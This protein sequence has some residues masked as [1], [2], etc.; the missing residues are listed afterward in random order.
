MTDTAEGERTVRSILRRKVRR[1]LRRRRSQII[2]VA[3]TVFLGVVLFTANLDASHNLGASYQSF[4]DQ[5]DTADVWATGGPTDRMAADFAGTPGVTAVDT[6]S[7]VDLPARLDGRE[8]VATMIGGPEDGVFDVNRLWIDKGRDLRPGDTDVV[9]LEKHA[10]DHFHLGP[11]D[12]VA[13]WNGSAWR[14]V[15]IVGV[16]A[17]GEY[18]F[19]ARSHTEVFT[20]P[21]EFAVV[22]VP[23][24]LAREIAPDAPR[25]VAV[26]VADRDP[27]LSA[28]LISRARASG[29]TEIYDLADQPSN[30]ALQSDV[31]GFES[32]SYLF[33]VLFL[34]AAG[35]ATFVLLSRLV[36][37]ER[38]QIGMMVADGIDTSTILRHYM[39]HALI[40]TMSGAI[41]GLIAGALLGRWISTLYTGFIG[42]PV[43]VM[44]YSVATMIEAV[45]FAVIVGAISG[46]LPARAAA[47]IDPAESMRPPTPTGVDSR[48]LLERV[49]PVTMPMT[50]KVVL[51]NMARNPRRVATTAVGVVLSMVLLVTSL[52][53]N[54][55]TGSVID[56]QFSAID[57]RDLSVHLDHPVTEADLAGLATIPQVA[58]AE[59]SLELPVVVSVDGRRSEQLLQVFRSNTDAHGFDR[60][61]PTTG[62][63]LGSV[64]RSNLG[65]RV[66]DVVTV[67]VPSMGASIE[68]PVTGFVDEPI[69]S[70]SY[71]SLAA[72][73]AA[74]GSAPTTAVVTLVD[75][76]THAAV[77]DLLARRADVLAVTDHRAMID[78]IRELL[79]ITIVFVGLMVVFAVLMTIG[80]LFNAVTVALAERTNEMATLQA[81]GM[82]RRWIR[83]T[84]TAE[85]LSVAL[86][87]LAPGAV[88]GWFVAGRFMSQFNNESFSFDMVLKGRSMALAVVLVLGVAVLAQLPGLRRVDRL[89]LPSVVRERS[90]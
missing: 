66:G 57:R 59:P 58:T 16:A 28:T 41:P 14:D 49:W 31:K 52:A 85:T 29:A 63:V 32:M 9:V 70:V 76:D 20:I 24:S 82:P 21:D 53:L 13:L 79:T 81:N 34:G 48:A 4:Y 61:L 11:G 78:T 86:L 2:A 8:L 25:Q 74:G 10:A 30:L 68:A 45:L 56:R 6:R 54:D 36:R 89:D 71:T 26:K 37:Q 67:S 65:V 18:L 60:P 44:H 17:S 12:T 90:V 55:T 64:A 73:T 1:D 38:T 50:A 40:A 7:K 42:V 84:V 62:V 75:H 88:L 47:S 87:G 46:A 22:F 35:M 43:T 3:G 39:S 19:P 72:W 15:E 69:P 33:P 80:L 23:E 5:L 77:R 51:R 27:E 83:T